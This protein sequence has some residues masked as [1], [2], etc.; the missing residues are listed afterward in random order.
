MA[1]VE[2]GIATVRARGGEV[3]FRNGRVVGL[4]AL[5]A[6]VGGDG[7]R[8]RAMAVLCLQR[9]RGRVDREDVREARERLSG[10]RGS[11]P[12]SPLAG[13]GRADRDA[14]LAVAA[15]M[16]RI[17]SQ[18]HQRGRHPPETPANPAPGPPPHRTWAHAATEGQPAGRPAQAVRNGTGQ[19]ATQTQALG[20][21]DKLR[22]DKARRTLPPELEL[23]PFELP[24]HGWPRAASE[25]GPKE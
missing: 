16:L 12:R 22:E 13:M 19:N 17:A 11:R 6:E 23:N 21:L 10:G 14:I 4:A 7:D 24:E 25:T 3:A 15:E 18:A 20:L 9:E 5:R 8:V 1:D 2:R